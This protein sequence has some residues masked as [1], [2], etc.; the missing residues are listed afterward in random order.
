ML[1]LLTP[2]V[3]GVGVLE[4]ISVLVP[5]NSEGLLW[6]KNSNVCVK[7]FTVR[8]KC[9]LGHISAGASG[10]AGGLAKYFCIQPHI[11]LG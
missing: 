3:W 10:R 2:I 8:F 9:I 6:N 4:I 5:A 7:G 1:L 11:V